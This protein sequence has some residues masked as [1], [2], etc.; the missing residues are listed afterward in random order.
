MPTHFL[1]H[2]PTAKLLCR[3]QTGWGMDSFP[4]RPWTI[5][6]KILNVYSTKFLG[7]KIGKIIECVLHETPKLENW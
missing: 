1:T 7:W 4:P 5:R 3:E 6:S 2:L